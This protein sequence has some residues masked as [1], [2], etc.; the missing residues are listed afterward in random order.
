M[1]LYIHLELN[2][3]H[4]PPLY[5]LQFPNL[6]EKRKHSSSLNMNRKML[7][8]WALGLAQDQ[9]WRKLYSSGSQPGKAAM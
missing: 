4:E 9:S 5:T 6:F 3:S 2:V 8:L 1:Q 7:C